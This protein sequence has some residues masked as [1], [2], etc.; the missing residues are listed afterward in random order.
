MNNTYTSIL[1]MFPFLLFFLGGG[2]VHCDLYRTPV[3]YVLYMNYYRVKIHIL[4]QELSNC[5]ILKTVPTKT[6]SIFGLYASLVLHFKHS[7]NFTCHAQKRPK[8]K[9]ILGRPY[10]SHMQQSQKTCCNLASTGSFTPW[11]TQAHCI[12]PP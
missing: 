5:T 3:L 1:V 4:D 6:Q 9:V 2:G 12:H 8:I 10:Q 11:L 7:F